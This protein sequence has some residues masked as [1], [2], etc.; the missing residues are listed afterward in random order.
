MRT[1][2]QGLWAGLAVMALSMPAAWGAEEKVPLDKLPKSVADAVKA[3]FPSAELKGAEKEEAEGKTVFEVSLKFK[4]QNYDVSLTPEGTITEIEKTIDA[5]DLP[6]AV[7]KALD[8]KYAKATI[9]LAEEVTKD[10]KTTYELQI[11]TADKK[12]MEVVFDAAGKMTKEEAKD[13]EEEEESEEGEEEI[14]LDQLPKAVVEAVK[15]KFAGAELNSAAKE[16]HGDSIVYEVSITHK[17]HAID[18]MASP[19]GKIIAVEKTIKANELPARISRALAERFSRGTV[20]KA[21]EL[22]KDSKI[23]YEVLLEKSDGTTVELVFD[24]NGKVLEEEAR[25]KK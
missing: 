9:R 14:S 12:K 8:Q 17:E 18:V 10:N 13:N 7:T 4:G 6:A 16:K 2:I 3:K 11:E 1:I 15:A 22:T 25:E 19:E 24:S 20:K 23:T 5:K 21:E